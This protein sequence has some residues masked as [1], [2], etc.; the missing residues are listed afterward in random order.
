[1]RSSD[2][3]DL[4][5]EIYPLGKKKSLFFSGGQKFF[6]GG[7]QKKLEPTVAAADV[8]ISRDFEDGRDKKRPF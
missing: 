4:N 7:K 1:M 2:L 8:I 3:F 5:T 6:L